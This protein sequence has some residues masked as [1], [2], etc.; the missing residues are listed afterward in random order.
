MRRAARQEW[1]WGWLKQK[2]PGI[3]ISAFFAYI[4]FGK[5]SINLI[6]SFIE[7]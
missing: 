2:L 5:V 4:H 6:E 7:A 3:S 1:E